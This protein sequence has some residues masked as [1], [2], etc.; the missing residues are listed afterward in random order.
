MVLGTS[1]AA[2]ALGWT[3]IF[4]KHENFRNLK[5]LSA[6]YLSAYILSASLSYCRKVF[7][8]FIVASR[9]VFYA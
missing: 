2:M 7:V 5:K 6:Q 3:V 1:G 9:V 4:F 8:F